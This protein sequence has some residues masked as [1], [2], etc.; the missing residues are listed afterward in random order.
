MYR[1]LYLPAEPKVEVI[2]IIAAFPYTLGGEV[3]AKLGHIQ[4]MNFPFRWTIC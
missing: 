1:V 4:A 3:E 2:A